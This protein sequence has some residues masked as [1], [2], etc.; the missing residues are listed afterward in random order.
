MEHDEVLVVGSG[1]SGAALAWKL[2]KAGFRVTCLEQGGW[3]SPKDASTT[4]DDWERQR[5][6]DES[7]NPNIR[8]GAYDYPLDESDTPIKPLMFNG[9]GGSTIKWGAHFPRFRPSDFRVRSLDGLA[10][11]WPF[12]YDALAPFYDENDR[13]MGVSGLAGDPGNPPRSA[14]PMPPLP[15]GPGALRMGQAFDKLGWQWWVSDVAINSTPYGTRGACNNCGPCDMGCPPQA[16]ASTDITYWPLALAAGARLITHAR[17]FEVT[18]DA[19]GRPTGVAYFD[20]NRQVQLRSA[21]IVVLAANG[22][23]TP[24][25]MLLSAS[26]KHPDGLLN[27]SGLVGRRLMHHPT[28]LVTGIFD[29][30][31]EGYKGPFACSFLCQEFYETRPEHGFVRGYQMQVVRS[32][33]PLGTAL[34]GY[35]P[36]IRWGAD[37]HRDFLDCFGHTASLTVTTED[38]PDE[39]NRVTLDPAV[40]DGFGIPAVKLHYRVDENT[41]AMIE[42]GIEKASLAFRT[43][44][45]RRVEAQRLVAQAGFH[46]MGTARMGDDP[47]TSVVDGFCRAH[48][49]DNLLIIDGSVFVTGAAL[50][51][52]PTIQAIALRAADNLIRNRGNQTV[53]TSPTH[54]GWKPVAH[55]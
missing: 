45:A 5:Y 6:T 33:G 20:Q 25:L 24:R 9:V 28:G 7:A 8:R 54:T 4:G 47:E 15:P 12:D 43:A 48:D 13:M 19:D 50:N 35:V 2:A 3:V 49:A 34:G 55:G 1:A 27:R 32:D 21:D 38:L 14:R 22:V 26:G 46:L 40:T 31:L 17:V 18:T 30:P 37:H 11:D 51:P 36:R 41:R 29:E 23:G 16:R 39:N 42:H 53:S 52:T 10:D 44:G